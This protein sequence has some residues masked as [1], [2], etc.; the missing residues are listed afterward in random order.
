M[1]VPLGRRQARLA[2][3]YAIVTAL[4][5]LTAHAAQLTY[6]GPVD[7]HGTGLGN[8]ATVLTIG[9]HGV[10]SGCVSWN[11]SADIM[12]PGAPACPSGIAGGDEKA[13]ASPT[14]TRRLGDVGSPTADTL[15][16]IFNANEPGS[17]R[18]LRLESLVLR[19]VSPAGA[20]VFE[21]AL[22]AGIDIEAT[23][24]GVGN[25]GWAFGLEGASGD[26]SFT[27]A[28]NRIGLAAT[29]SGADGGFETFY[30]AQGESGG[31][32]GGFETFYVAQGESGGG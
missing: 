10:E 15:R 17:N 13:G 31:G 24:S 19:V 3:V 4:T 5:S 11:G 8:V 20:V 27:N 16:V 22:P 25:S 29:V 30:V 14:L 7:E 23:D 18:A 21:A 26:A 9:N 32:G 2:L 12:G 28:E 1:R 6:L